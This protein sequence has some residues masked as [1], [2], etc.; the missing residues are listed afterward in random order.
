[1]TPVEPANFDRLDLDPEIPQAY[2]IQALGGIDCAWY[3]GQKT[4]GNSR[5]LELS[6]LP[7]TSAVWNEFVD[8]S[9]GVTGTTYTF[10]TS[11]EQN[12]CE[13]DAFVNG[14]WLYILA[15]NLSVQPGSGNTTLPPQLKSAIT[16]M[17]AKL[18]A[19]ALGPAPAL[20]QGS[21]TLP[22]T[23]TSLITAAQFTTALGLG[24][25]VTV[26]CTG[27][28]DGPW[29]LANEAETEVTSAIGCFFAT[30]D[31]GGYG[32]YEWLAGGAWAAELAE[33]ATPSETALTVPGLPAG[34]SAKEYSD[35]QGELTVDLIL[36]GN[37]IEYEL[38]PASDTGEPPGS[39]PLP[40]AAIA[41]TSAFEKTVRG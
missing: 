22:N 36:G 23:G 16:A 12:T 29:S 5:D 20:R 19:A 25:G 24:G 10:C 15:N 3:D 31:G 18:T 37:W 17:T 9:E 1:M 13:Y 27:H 38:A 28:P 6:V 40:T 11:D 2:Y 7:A 26:D 14:S 34:D 39:V 32:G 35:S 41:L 8:S 30:S 4:S 21:V 33:A